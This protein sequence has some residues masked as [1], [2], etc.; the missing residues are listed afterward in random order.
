MP[1]TTFKNVG[2]QF[3]PEHFSEETIDW[4]LRSPKA[5]VLEAMPPEPAP[6]EPTPEA[7]FAAAWAECLEDADF[8][9]AIKEKSYTEEQGRSEF[10]KAIAAPISPAVDTRLGTLLKVDYETRVENGTYIHLLNGERILTIPA[11]V[12]AA[13]TVSANADAIIYG[14]FLVVDVLMIVAASAGVYIKLP[15]KEAVARSV[16]P[17]LLR[18]FE[19][20]CSPATM[21]TLK[22]LLTNEKVIQ[23]IFAVLRNVRGSVSLRDV[24]RAFLGSLSWIDRAIILVQLVAQV[25]LVVATFGEILAIRILQLTGASLIFVGDAVLFV[26]ALEKK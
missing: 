12:H 11:T 21:E 23:L 4:L 1:L 25:I 19:W 24:L 26:E 7:A 6:V 5:K 9:R 8:Q 15:G 14:G 16:Q 18:F 17:L 22:P 2:V 13:A 3:S 20:L 10:A